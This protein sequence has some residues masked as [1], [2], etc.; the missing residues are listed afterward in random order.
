MSP[1]RL[2]QMSL[3]MCNPKPTPCGFNSWFA[4]S[5]LKGLKSSSNSSSRMP[6]P[7]SVTLISRLMSSPCYMRAEWISITPLLLG[8]N[9][10]ALESKLSRTCCTRSASP[11]SM[12]SSLKA[13]SEI[14]L[15]SKDCMEY[16]MMSLIEQ[17]I[18]IGEKTSS[19]AKKLLCSMRL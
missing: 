10:R 9:L 17:M 1:P 19:F 18:L 12:V 4:F 13:L 3:Q 6:G 14:N 7:L 2:V 8:T 15:T 16:S 5:L 11:I